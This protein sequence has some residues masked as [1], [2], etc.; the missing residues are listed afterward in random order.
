ML[1]KRIFKKII[2]QFLKAV[3][4]SSFGRLTIMTT[5]HY[6]DFPF[7]WLTITMTYHHNESPFRRLTITTNQYFDHLPL[8][9]RGCASVSTWKRGCASVSTWKRD[10]HN[11]PLR[12][13]RITTATF[14]YDE[15]FLTRSPHHSIS[16]V[17]H[18]SKIS[19]TPVRQSQAC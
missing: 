10:S 13:L 11:F 14:H 12:R 17:G 19:E 15:T 2:K 7:Q 1:N 16:R 5:H 4:D 3:D 18:V 9:K 6:D 8:R